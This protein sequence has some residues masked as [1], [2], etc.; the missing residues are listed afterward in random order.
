MS[1]LISV[2]VGAAYHIVSAIARALAPAAGGL[3]TAAAII[4]FTAAVRLVLLPLSY[5]GMRG[6][7]RIAGL[8]AKAQALRE[9]HAGQPDRQQRELAALYQREG[10]GMLTGCLPV[11][12]QLPFLSVMYT[13]FRSGSI[14]GHPNGLLGHYLLTAP[15]GSHWL[16]GPGP[17]SAQGAVFAGVFVLLAVAAWL[18]A[19]AARKT[20]AAQPP[21]T[22]APATAR[23]GPAGSRQSRPGP[24]GSRQSRPGPSGSRQSRPGPS[25]SR[26]SR[27]GPSGSRQPGA[28]QP[29]GAMGVLVRVMPYATLVIAA[30]MPLAAGLYLLT[31]T[32]WAAVERTVLARRVRP[33]AAADPR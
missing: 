10:G 12:A 1:A 32:A 16:T 18:A 26:Q 11:L 2:A 6:Q 4:L 29:G 28:A 8:A 9:Q 27:P 23:P 3:A 19:R 30:V 7:A 14:D 15:L 25:G 5:L 13:L 24:S 17:I 20:A 21:Q 22:V 33:P 31:T